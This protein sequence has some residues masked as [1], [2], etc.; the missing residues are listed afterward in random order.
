MGLFRKRTYLDYASATPVSSRVR[1]VYNRAL[2]SYGNPSS[3]HEEGRAA[4]SLLRDARH[5][6]A[7]EV[8]AKSDDV[9]FTASATE[10]NN[11]A[12]QGVVRAFRAQGAKKVHV[13][14]LPSAHAS[15]IE[16]V[17]VLAQDGV[18]TEPLSVADGAVDIEAF[19]KQVRPETV[20][21]SMDRVCGE[22][23]ALWDTRAVRRALDEMSSVSNHRVMLHVDALHAPRVESVERTR[24][25]ADLITFDAQKVGGVRGVAALIVSRTTPIAPLLFGG[26][27]ERALS[28]GTENVAAVAAFAEAFIETRAACASFVRRA[29]RY[30]Q[31]VLAALSG[32]A[33]VYENRGK[34]QMPHTLNISLVG[35]DTDYLVALLDVAGFA[36]STKS[37]CETDSEEGSR[38]VQVLTGDSARASATLRISFGRD[39]SM[40]DVRRFTRALIAAVAFLDSHTF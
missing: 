6:I 9:V 19:K 38:A 12:I 34:E 35:R 25:G 13:L 39:T 36:V 20:L 33:Q 21:V 3:P 4:A 24:I 29:K 30:R 28:P 7:K 1:R 11:L 31:Y 17:E 2:A 15:V 10:A 5:A 14:Y 37:A 32:V 40:R 27:Q 8:E 16:S 26:T 18:S 22:T 23:G